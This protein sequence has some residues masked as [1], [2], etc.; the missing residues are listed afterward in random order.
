M[1]KTGERKAQILQTLAAMLEDP[2]GERITTALLAARLEVSEAALYRHFAS[3]AQMFEGLIEF[4]EQTV[5]SLVNKIQAEETDAMKQVEATVATLLG[6]A[7]KNP[8]MTRVLIGDALVNEDERLQARVNQ[9]L[10][11]LEA[12]LRQSARLAVTAGHPARRLGRERLRQRGHR[13]RGRALAP[14]RQERLQARADGGL[15]AAVARLRGLTL[16]LPELDDR[17][18]RRCASRAPAW[19]ARDGALPLR[20]LR[21]PPRPLVAAR[22]R[23]ASSPRRS[24]RAPRAS[25]W[26]SSTPT[27]RRASCCSRAARA[28]SAPILGTCNYT[29]IV[30]GAFQACHLGYQI[31]RDHEGQGLMAEALRATNAFV[32]DAHAPAPHHGQLPAGERAQP[33]ACS[34]AWA[35]CA[36]GSRATTSSS[37]A[38]G[39]TTCSPSLTQPAF[40]RRL[41]AAAAGR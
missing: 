8:G 26:R 31:A 13:V 17:A 24:G 27:A 16:M 21:R 9:L 15:G 19:Q 3:K 36:R 14:V 22:R 23:R 33:R 32:F 5:F 30:R 4:I 39:A 18:P 11:R 28:E 2:K 29:N 10:D 1:A 41:A 20:E 12:S 37:T 38:R 34:S 25:P 40:R 7:Q 35:S 6:F